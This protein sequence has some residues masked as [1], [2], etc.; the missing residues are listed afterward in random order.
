MTLNVYI[1]LQWQKMSKIIKF[2]HISSDA[3]DSD[4]FLDTVDIKELADVLY[5]AEELE[6]LGTKGHKLARAM[7][8]VVIANQYLDLVAAETIEGIDITHHG[9]EF[10]TVH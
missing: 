4:N 3:T 7:A 8:S 10:E 1:L 5:K 9:K 6:G 2:S